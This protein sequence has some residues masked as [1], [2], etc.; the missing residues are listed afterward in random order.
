MIKCE[1][2]YEVSIYVVKQDI[3]NK[4]YSNYYNSL[5]T[6]I[7]SKEK[8]SASK[9][10]TI[11]YRIASSLN[12]NKDISH[13]LRDED[14]KELVIRNSKFELG[15]TDGTKVTFDKE[16]L[17][18]VSITNDEI[19]KRINYDLEVFISI[20][21]FFDILKSSNNYITDGSFHGYYYFDNYKV[22]GTNVYKSSFIL[23]DK[24]EID[25]E[26]E[27]GRLLSQEKK[28]T[29]YIPG[30]KY[31]LKN[32]DEILYLGSVSEFKKNINGYEKHCSVFHRNFNSRLSDY[33]TVIPKATQNRD[34]IIN[35][36]NLDDICSN[37]Y[38]NTSVTSFIK[39]SK[40]QDCEKFLTNWIEYI[41]TLPESEY[42]VQ[43]ILE[44]CLETSE[45]RNSG[46]DM[47][48]FLKVDPV[49][50]LT[51]TINDYCIK[52][53]TR[54]VSLLS[55]IKLKS[56]SLDPNIKSKIM[57][58]Q[59][60]TIK[61][62]I[63]NIFSRSYSITSD[64]TK[65]LKEKTG[66]DLIKYLSTSFSGSYYLYPLNNLIKDRIINLTDEEK[67]SIVDKAKELYYKG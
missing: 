31:L 45:T 38:T 23:D 42:V 33:E 39:A 48:E 60:E 27:K 2:P 17:V 9:K 41:I 5:K 8:T 15:V 14:I 28:T 58:Y 34:L 1:I 50:D 10:E 13:K 40:G 43:N 67:S 35:L 61:C 54:N 29:T 18:S 12:N 52:N 26:V 6:Y 65:N 47:G 64:D 4:Y 25:G 53:Y 30:H 22:S 62:M 56:G 49:I 51:D 37:Y 7:V 11:F 57:E 66:S 19:K 24:N 3:W 63:K 55:G 16:G 59:T 44:T 32:R 20:D 21:N 46:V 36:T